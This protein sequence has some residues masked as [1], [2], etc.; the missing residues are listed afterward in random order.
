L[1]GGTPLIDLRLRHESTR[2]S[3]KPRQAEAAT[4][5]ARF[6]YRTGRFSGFSALAEA[7][8]LHHIGT[9]RFSNG[10]DGRADYPVVA[11]PDMV[12]L[13][14][15]QLDFATHLAASPNGPADLD[16]VLGRQVVIFSDM[17]F[18]GNSAWRQHEQT[19]D[20][21]S[22]VSTSLPHTNITYSYVTRVNR[23]LGPHTAAG[24]L[25][26]DSH[27][28]NVLYAG[29]PN[30][31]IE[32]YLYLLDFEQAPAL[33]SASYGVRAEGSF[34]LGGGVG[35]NFGGAIARQ[36]DYG[37]NPLSIDLGDYRADGGFSFGGFSG[38]MGYEV[39]EGNGT[40]GFQTPL[41]TGHQFQGW[42][43]TF[44]SKPPDGV[45]DFYLKASYTMSAMPLL[46]RVTPSLAY[47]DFSAQHVRGDYG[48][49]WDTGLQA[50]LDDRLTLDLAYADYRAAGPFPDKRSF[51]VYTTYHY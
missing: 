16:I 47:H 27:F 35:V 49:E 1:A 18:V 25:D 28:L 32:G 48:S 21:V 31:R 46:Q 33:S 5:R 36:R 51:W 11:D 34:D 41:G 40:I 3:D 42:A 38:L 6:G 23:P 29:L 26:S 4:L 50:Q 24:H 12:A 8:V 22:V 9:K 37:R 2:E 44:T 30:V 19:F 17:R 14:R 10:V 13:N 39:L 15:L 20:A 7:D 45:K 43:E